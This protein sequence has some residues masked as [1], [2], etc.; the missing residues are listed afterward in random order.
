MIGPY[1]GPH[2]SAQVAPIENLTLSTTIDLEW[3]HVY[4]GEKASAPSIRLPFFFKQMFVCLTSSKFT[5]FL[6][7]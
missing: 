7:L 4:S 3:P 1:L 5:S 6:H 2:L